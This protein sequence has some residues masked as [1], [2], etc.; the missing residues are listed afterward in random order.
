MNELKQTKFWG[1]DINKNSGFMNFQAQSVDMGPSSGERSGSCCAEMLK[2]APKGPDFERPVA[3]DHEDLSTGVSAIDE[4]QTGPSIH[5]PR[6]CSGINI[7]NCSAVEL[8]LSIGGGSIGEKR[9]QRQKQKY[10]SLKLDDV[11]D[12]DS[13]GLVKTVVV[14]GEEF[15]ESDDHT[16]V[17]SSSTNFNQNSKQ[18]AQW[19]F[20]DLSLS[21]T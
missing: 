8:T 15:S 4:Q 1:F 19:I 12:M 2:M 9:S 5:I 6:K 11:R 21:R 7:D 20:Q 16:A 17:T 18:Q 14:N 13:S 10:C 3:A